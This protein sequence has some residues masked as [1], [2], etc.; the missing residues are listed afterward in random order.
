MEVFRKERK[1]AIENRLIAFTTDM[2]P[3][4]LKEDIAD[5]PIFTY[6]YNQEAIERYLKTNRSNRTLLHDYLNQELGG[7]DKMLFVDTGY[8]G[9][10]TGY[11]RKFF[12]KKETKDILL[13]GIKGSNCFR[14]DCTEENFTNLVESLKHGFEIEGLKRENGKIVVVK[15]P[16]HEHARNLHIADYSA[17]EILALEYIHGKVGEDRIKEV[18]E[19]VKYT[20]ARL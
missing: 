4:K 17:I 20:A 9:R 6:E 19:R 3:E 7:L 2:L 13:F 10:C 11:M 5:F 8:W 16:K 18:L 1:L 14:E 12:S 15:R